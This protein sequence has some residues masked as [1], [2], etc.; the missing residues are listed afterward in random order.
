MTKDTT[1][2]L[3]KLAER[4]ERCWAPAIYTC[5]AGHFTLESET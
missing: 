4:W 3:T 2:E 5:P 1:I